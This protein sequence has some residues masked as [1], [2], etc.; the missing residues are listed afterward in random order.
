MVEKPLRTRRLSIN[1]INERRGFFMKIIP[2]MF[3]LVL[4]GTSAWAFDVPS[5][6]DGRSTRPNLITIVTDDQG[7]WAMGTY[8]NREIRTPNMDRIGREGIVFTNAFVVTPVCSPSRAVYLT[9]RWPT[10][11]GIT[12]WIAP[13]EA[14]N[15]LGLKG[16]TWPEVLRQNGY[17]T[18]LVGKWHLGMEP[19]YHPGKLGFD[20]FMGFL[21]GGNRPMNPTLEVNGENKKL[22]G[23]LPDLLVDDAIGFVKRNSRRPFALSLHFRAPH[24]PYGPVPKQD[25]TP[26][27]DLDPQVPVPRGAVA[28]QIKKWNRDY[29]ASITSIDRNIGRLLDALDELKLTKNTIVLFTS[30]HGYNNGRHNINTK[31]NGHWIAGGVNGPKRPNMWDTSIRVPLVIRWPGVIPPGTRNDA[32]V[33]NL[34]MFRT[35]IGILDIPWKDLPDVHGKDFS[36]VLRGKKIAETKAIFGQYDLHNNGLAYLRMI[37]TKKFKFVKHYRTNFMDELYDVENDPD[38]K[39]NLMRGRQ[40]GRFRDTAKDLEK[41]L[42]EWQRS[43]DDPILKLD[44]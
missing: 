22:N 28:K 39:R 14:R 35:V 1:F 40:S 33:T 36:P 13:I 3:V 26:Y 16:R 18:G 42:I 7:R 10:E 17:R 8:G 15:G 27:K 9:G 38:E 41:T 32:L 31:G 2:T 12:D 34:D 37:R 19:E 4:L 21:G 44:Y 29:Y 5:R 6:Q 20:H 30:D 11:L 23:P 25:S 43:I 24:L